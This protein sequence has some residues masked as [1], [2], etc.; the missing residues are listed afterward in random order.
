M[1]KALTVLGLLAALAIPAAAVADATLNP[2]NVG[3]GCEGDGEYHFVA[4]GGS[5]TDVLN[6]FFTGG[7]AIGESPD[8]VTNG[9]AHFWVDASGTVLGTT[10]VTGTATKLVLSQSICGDGK[11]GGGGPK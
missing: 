6:A 11:G 8:S 10:N 5:A 9:V 3:S 1:R 7:S 4:K 2:G